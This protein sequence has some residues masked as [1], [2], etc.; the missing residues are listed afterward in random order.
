MTIPI[1][2]KL[3]DVDPPS[4]NDP[5]VGLKVRLPNYCSCGSRIAM[6]YP[7]TPTHRAAMRCLECDRFRAWMSKK[8][9]DFVES[10]AAKFG[11]PEIIT[12]RV[13]KNSTL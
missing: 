8:T 1:Q 7:G 10:V 9:G 4:S 13:P 12:V 3:F 6:I 11:G 2:Q 5:I